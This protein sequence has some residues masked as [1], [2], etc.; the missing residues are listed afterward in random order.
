VSK[1]TRYCCNQLNPQ[2]EPTTHERPTSLRDANRRRPANQ[3]DSRV[4]GY[5]PTA[6][7]TPSRL[8]STHQAHLEWTRSRMVHWAQTIGPHTARLFERRG[9]CS[10]NFCESKPDT[11]IGLCCQS[12]VVGPSPLEEPNLEPSNM[13]RHG[14]ICVDSASVKSSRFDFRRFR[15]IS[16]S[17][18]LVRSGRRDLNSGP[19]A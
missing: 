5:A 16:A 18:W 13:R 10:I 8:P 6:M 11:R 19:L 7:G 9:A 3:T 4:Q 15:K 17:D 2:S 1:P 14:G 12:R